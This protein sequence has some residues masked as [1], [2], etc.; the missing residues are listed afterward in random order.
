MGSCLAKDIM[1]VLLRYEL[2]ARKV[3]RRCIV[4][5]VIRESATLKV[6]TS[7]GGKPI[8][9][10]FNCLSLLRDGDDL[11]TWSRTCIVHA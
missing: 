4:T 11:A 6:G 2:V 3:V 10:L 5:L 8:R 1:D 9:S 7:K